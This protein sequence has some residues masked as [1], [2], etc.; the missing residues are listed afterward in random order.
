M[1]ICFDLDGTLVNTESWILNSF[2]ESFKKNKV[3]ISNKELKKHWGLMAREIVKKTNS[4]LTDSQIKKII[5]DFEEIRSKTFYQIKPFKN[6]NKLLK[7]LSKKHTLTL[8]SNNQHKKI[9]K[10]L[11]QTKIDKKYF[12]IILGYND[13]SKPKPFPTGVHKIE[14]KLKSKVNFL[15]GDTLQDIK[16]AKAAKTKSI[17]V[18]TGPKISKKDLKKADFII[19][20][21]SQ[22]KRLL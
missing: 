10:I 6:T 22:I 8:L 17:I 2:Q 18:L 7:E 12:K 14:H 9:N 1:I 20:E 19:K 13:V 11:K 16:T 4:K 15:V 5:K 21:I 3:K